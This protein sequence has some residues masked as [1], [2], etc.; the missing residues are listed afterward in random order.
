MLAYSTA[1]IADENEFY[2]HAYCSIL[3]TIFELKEVVAVNTTEEL[4]QSLEPDAAQLIFIDALLPGGDVAGLCRQL[5]R[6]HPAV[7]IV[8]I[9]GSC[10]QWL[11][12]QLM[13]SGVHGI[14]PKA[15]PRQ[16]IRECLECISRNE[17]FYLVRTAGG[18][19]IVKGN[20]EVSFNRTEMLIMQKLFE[21]KNTKQI[22][23]EMHLSPKTVENYRKALL[24]KT[25][26]QNVAGI[27]RYAW[28]NGIVW[29]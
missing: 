20:P 7:T 10:G 26:S 18:D 29:L 9:V 16:K 4:L 15:S 14:I 21:G 5:V 12:Q 23:A 25:G 17:L 22:A 6:L 28:L 27:I 13:Q 3:Q 2:H 24:V 19:F 8:V 11:Q 1:I